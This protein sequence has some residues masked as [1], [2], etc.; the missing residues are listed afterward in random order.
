MSSRAYV[1]VTRVDGKTKDTREIMIDGVKVAELS[2]LELIEF[3]AQATLS[4]RD[5]NA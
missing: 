5:S 2:S 4:L 3:I 1:R